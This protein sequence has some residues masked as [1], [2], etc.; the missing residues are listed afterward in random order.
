MKIKKVEL[1]SFKRFTDL[2][3]DLIPEDAKLVLLIGANG[4]G[5]SCIFDA[6]EFVSGRRKGAP[7][8]NETY[9]RKIEDQ[10]YSINISSYEGLSAKHDISGFSV[11][12]KAENFYGRSSFRQVPRLTRTSLGQG[13]IV[14]IEKDTDRPRTYIDRDNRFENDIERITEIILKEFFRTETTKEKIKET[15]IEPINKA[16]ENIFGAGNGTKLELVE[17]IPPLEGKVAQINFKKGASEIHYNFLSA[18][19]KEV[20]N[21][22][23]NLLSRKD[24]YKDTI[25]FYDEL[26]IHLNTKLQFN[27]LKEIVEHWIPDNCQLWTASHS[28]GFIDYANQSKSSVILDFDDLDYDKPQII[29]PQL[30]NDF[31]VFDIA[32]SKDFIS[33]MVENRRM[34]FSENKNTPV[35]ND[36]NLKDTL[37][38][39]GIDKQDVFQKS[40]N[41]NT[42]GLVDRDFLTDDEIQNLLSVYSRLRILN[43]YSIENYYYHPDNLCEYFAKKE[44]PFDRALYVSQLTNAKNKEKTNIVYG[45]DSARRGYPFYKENENAALKKSFISNGRAIVNMIESDDFEIFYKVFPAK[46]YGKAIPERQH[47]IPAELAKTDWFK[48][49]ISEII[50]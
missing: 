21:I 11:N 29:V 43:F 22:L 34:V 15:Y 32:V 6:F 30:K 2:T 4:S 36:L 48:L 3:I 35:Y 14:D 20:F 47:I 7:F 5:K 23:I 26:D 44:V 10:L 18:G 37:F 13:E 39:V 45:I 12:F 25:Y 16:L 33:R 24:Y 8:E 17:I 42:L 27:M 40:I 49:Q 28:L 41:L 38:C 19:E 31:A 1:Q 50:G 46:D 9:Y